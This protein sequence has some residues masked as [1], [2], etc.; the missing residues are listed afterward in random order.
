MCSHRPDRRRNRVEQN[1]MREKK[2]SAAALQRMT[3]TTASTF[4]PAIHGKT[5][6]QKTADKLAEALGYK[7][8]AL[9]TL[10][11]DM[12]PLSPKIQDTHFVKIDIALR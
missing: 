3:G 7:T 1:L 9:F 8:D 4:A 12:T 6:S 2:L 10:V 11:R 5:V